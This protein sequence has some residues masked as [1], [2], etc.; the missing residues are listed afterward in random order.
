M[1]LFE[2]L[3]R[4]DKQTSRHTDRKISTPTGCRFKCSIY[5]YRQGCGVGVGVLP[6]RG[7]HIGRTC[8]HNLT[9]YNEIMDCVQLT[10]PRIHGLLF[11]AICE[12]CLSAS[13]TQYTV[14]IT[15]VPESVSDFNPESES[16]SHPKYVDS[17]A[18]LA[19]DA[20][21]WSWDNQLTTR[22]R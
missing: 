1:W 7:L 10:K 16:E 17:A 20:V 3:E 8:F 19:T 15:Q 5:G 11:V 2:V 12:I 21:D 9:E 22:R 6:K 13:F 14:T 4:T 18:F